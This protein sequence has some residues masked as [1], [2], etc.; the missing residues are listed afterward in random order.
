MPVVLPGDRGAVRHRRLRGGG[1][2]AWPLDVSRL[3]TGRPVQV[4][5][6]WL[7][8]LDVRVGGIAAR[9]LRLV[10]RDGS[11]LRRHVP[12]LLLLDRAGMV[13]LVDVKPERLIRGPEVSEVFGWTGWSTAVDQVTRSCR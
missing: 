11:A 4:V 9:P 5:R 2:D 6:L 7:A 12:D 1:D 13:T 10:G 8:D 3:V